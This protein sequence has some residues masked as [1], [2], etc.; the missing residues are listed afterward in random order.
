MN[1]RKVFKTVGFANLLHQPLVA[2]IILQFPRQAMSTQAVLSPSK[3]AS[4]TL[5]NHSRIRFQHSEDVD[6]LYPLLTSYIQDPSRAKTV[7]ELVI[8][9]QYLSGSYGCTARQGREQ[10]LETVVKEEIQDQPHVELQEYTRGLDLDSN[11]TTEFIQSLDWK[12]RQITG[13]WQGPDC[14]LQKENFK[15]GTTA[16]VLLLS[17][18]HNISSLYLGESLYQQHILDYMLKGNYGQIKNPPLQKLRN[19]KFIPSFLSDPRGYATIEMFQYIQLIHRLP[20]LESVAMDGVQEYQAQHTFFVPRTGN[21]KKLEITRCDIDGRF[22]ALIISIPMALEELR[23]SLGGLWSRDTSLPYVRPYHIGKALSAHKDSLRVLDIDIDQ[24][25]QSTS[26]KEWDLTEDDDEEKIEWEVDWEQKMYGHDRIALD[27]AISTESEK[28]DDKKYGRTIG[29]L[30]D[31]SHLTH[32]SISIIT[33]LGTYDD[34]QPPYR[35]LKPAPFRLIDGLP[36]SLEYL[37]IYGYYRSHNSDVDEHIDELLAK[38]DAQLPNLK[39]IK[40]IDEPV[41]SVRD[42]FGT[43]GAGLD[44]DL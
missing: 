40:G 24:A 19:V 20:A 17:L 29:S 18:C 28:S 6:L 15:F 43:D 9:T 22:L 36:T 27:K 42:I 39:V 35:L 10:I 1:F 11:T 33:L 23:L 2:P 25:A 41:P 7:S 37:C 21:M 31:Y 32:L 44:D 12:Y 34:W 16:I 4:A 3:N 38:K 26:D 5:P 30:H 14:R 13:A 8:D